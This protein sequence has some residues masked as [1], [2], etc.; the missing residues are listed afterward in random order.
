MA[1]AV[2]GTVIN[3]LDGKSR[4]L[5]KQRVLYHMGSQDFCRTIN[6]RIK[7]ICTLGEKKKNS[8]SPF[9]KEMVGEREL[10]FGT[11]AMYTAIVPGKLVRES[12]RVEVM[13]MRMRTDLRVI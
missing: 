1:D 2:E 10:E 6:K 12:A 9:E 11:Q 3:G 7:Q 13:D 4:R 5:S 8:W